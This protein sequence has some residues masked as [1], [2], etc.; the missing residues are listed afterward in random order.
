MQL[1]IPPQLTQQDSTA[2]AAA[3]VFLS[4]TN[5]AARTG[6]NRTVA[7]RVPSTFRF[8]ARNQELSRSFPLSNFTRTSSSSGAANSP[9]PQF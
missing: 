8:G 5:R 4:D 6:R 1:A 7:R 9:K 3:F 2:A